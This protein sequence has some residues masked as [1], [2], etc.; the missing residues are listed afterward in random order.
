MQDRG[1]IDRY[2]CVKDGKEG[3]NGRSVGAKMGEMC[4][5][6][7]RIWAPRQEEAMPTSSV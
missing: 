2:R 6:V 5:I 3:R 1:E 7:G 4:R